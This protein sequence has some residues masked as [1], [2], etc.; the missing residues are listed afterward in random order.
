VAEAGLFPGVNYY[1]SCWYKRSEIGKRSAIFFSAAALAGSFGG[2][3][4]AAIAKMTGIGGLKGWQWI[5]ILEG[6]ATVII[7]IVSFWMVH[8]FPD[9]AKFL[10]KEDRYRVI[11]RLR[12][13]K[14]SSAEH[15]DFKM[16]YFWASVKDWKTYAFALIYTG[17]VMPLYAFSLFIPSIIKALGYTSTTANLL[18]VPPY[19]VAAVVTI[20]VGFLADKAR[21]RGSFNIGISIIGIV[22][23]A[24]LLGSRNAQIQYAGT[25]LGAVGI[26]PC[27]SNIISWA[28]NNTEG[29]Y[30]RGVTLGFV[31]GFGN[32]NG[33]VASNIYLAREATT[34]YTTGHAVILGYMCGLLCI[35]SIITHFALAAENR[36]RL[37]GKRDD[38][39]VGKSSSEVELLGDRRPDFVYTT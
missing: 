19:A 12:Q 26:F 13:D 37:A 20:T 17:A 23:F 30:K 35:G 18:S 21:H 32:L 5:F 24:M 33:V 3:L 29:V 1:L 38:R 15:E 11:R 9:D 4:A 27:I 10:S 34:G 6:L 36:K 25:F 14:Q 22:G 8:D 16:A 31:I 7:G 39:L 28:A 2:L